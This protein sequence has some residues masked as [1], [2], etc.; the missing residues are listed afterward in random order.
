LRIGH[1]EE[2]DL[3]DRARNIEQ[4]I[5]PSEGGQSLIDH[6]LRGGGDGQIGIDHQHFRAGGFHR[7]GGL[8]EVGTVAGNQDQGGKVPCEA[9]GG[10]LADAL[11][12]S[13]DDSNGFRH[14]DSPR[15]AR[16]RRRASRR[17]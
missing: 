5:D 4:G 12:G 3:R 6:P 13:G 17:G 15:L 8:L 16:E 9:D 14:L 11:A 1:L 2:V 10:R 7:F